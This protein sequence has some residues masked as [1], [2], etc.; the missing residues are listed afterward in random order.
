MCT[1]K[2]KTIV[3]NGFLVLIPQIENILQKGQTGQYCVIIII[4]VTSG[5]TPGISKVVPFSFPR[6]HCIYFI[7][8][9]VSFR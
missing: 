2:R 5:N 7:I 3:I 8:V 4:R 1:L 6:V 9:H